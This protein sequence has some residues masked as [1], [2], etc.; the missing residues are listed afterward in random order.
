MHG[1]TRDHAI[2]NKVQ[3]G[4]LSQIQ[5]FLVMLK[6]DFLFLN[7]FR[8]NYLNVWFCEIEIKKC[9]YVRYQ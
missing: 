4:F 9:D 2:N 7:S 1:E 3:Y 6:P 8:K 5:V